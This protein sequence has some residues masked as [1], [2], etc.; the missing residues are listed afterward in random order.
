MDNS[1]LITTP[2][3]EVWNAYTNLG[4]VA[5]EAAGER[6]E[7]A[8]V[9]M[10]SIAADT[11]RT[12]ADRSWALNG[13][14]FAYTESSFDAERIREVVFSKPPFDVYYT[15]T[16]G[17]DRDVM[18]PESKGDLQALE[19]ALVKLNLLSNTL[20]PNHYAISRM[21]VNAIFA[22]QRASVG[23]GAS[24][25]AEMAKE[26]ALKLVPLIESYSV[27]LPIDARPERYPIGMRMQTM[28]AHASSLTFA[29]THLKNQAYLDKGEALYN[30]TI[31]LGEAELMKPAEGTVAPDYDQVRNK[32]LFA[33]MFYA[34]RFWA[35]YKDND[36]EKIRGILHPLTSAD[37]KETNFY[38]NYLP[39]HK[40]SKI[41]PFPELREI[42][43]TMPELKEYLEGAGW[44]F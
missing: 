9:T 15:P 11:T 23:L 34:A 7:D 14:N 42:A 43:A 4:P 21:E 26:T 13:I 22:F 40:D 30:E 1:V 35:F 24:A 37:N 2:T 5:D 39:S 8:L 19:N 17:G 25:K 20:M 33:R 44:K 38:K 10:A 16:D 31:Q 18:H 28:F 32:M 29:G 41:T 3:R 36:P 27:L 6:V 12:Y